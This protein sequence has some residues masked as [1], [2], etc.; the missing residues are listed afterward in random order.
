M[1]FIDGKNLTARYESMVKDGRRPKTQ[2]ERIWSERKFN[3]DHEPGVFLWYPL[4]LGKLRA[5]T[6]RAHYYTTFIGSEDNLDALSERISK[7]I[8]AEMNPVGPG[9][10]ATTNLVPCVFLKTARSTKTK[11][12]DINLCVDVLEYVRQHA[13]DVMHLVGGD[14]DYLPLVTATMRAGIT[15]HLAAFSSGLAPRLRHSADTFTLL[16]GTYFTD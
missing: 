9:E 10:I 8:A 1:A 16:D 14:V 11:S 2:P 15:V 3:I 12:V 13:L 7:C 4:S 6:L 5:T